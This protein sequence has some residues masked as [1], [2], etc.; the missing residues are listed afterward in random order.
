MSAQP[1]E[2]AIPADYP[3]LR[4]FADDI[5]AAAERR[6][7]RARVQIAN[8]EVTVTMM[9]PSTPHRLIVN[10]LI[11][12]IAGQ[13]P[14]VR[15]MNDTNVEHPAVGI[16][17]VP[18]LFVVPKDTMDDQPE[19]GVDATTVLLVVEVVSK[20]NPG[21]DHITKLRDYPRMGIPVYVIIDPRDGTIT[22]HEESTTVSGQARYADTPRP[23]KFG[24]TAVPMGRWTIDTSGFRRYK[25]A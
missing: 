2:S 9:S 11:L 12:Q 8:H 3:S 6:G 23:Y 15:P 21:N 7:E 4:A 25:A 18:D 10:E 1:A 13:D 22:V 19:D 20:T 16:L 14:T 17:K 24:D 5:A